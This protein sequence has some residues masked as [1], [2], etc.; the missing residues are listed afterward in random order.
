MRIEYN[1]ET[2]ELT[3]KPSNFTPILIPKSWCDAVQQITIENFVKTIK[4]ILTELP[5]QL[6]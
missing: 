3:I 4:N 6:E 2:E 5:S 1:T